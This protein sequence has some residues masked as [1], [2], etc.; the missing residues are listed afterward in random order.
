LAWFRWTSLKQ[1]GPKFWVNSPH[2]NLFA[3]FQAQ[4]TP[5]VPKNN[6][7]PLLDFSV[8]EMFTKFQELPRNIL[9]SLSSFHSHLTHGLCIQQL[10]LFTLLWNISA[11]YFEHLFIRIAALNKIFLTNIWGC[12]FVVKP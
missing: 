4:T 6:Q 11:F 8:T 3:T 12:F 10:C 1:L 9:A 5:H 7:H 2:C